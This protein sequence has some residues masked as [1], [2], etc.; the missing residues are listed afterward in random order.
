M[1]QSKQKIKEEI[2]LYFQ[3]PIKTYLNGE[4][5]GNTIVFKSFCLFLYDMWYLCVNRCITAMFAAVRKKFNYEH[6]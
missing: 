2:I 1:N 6:I 4:Y 5:N 3:Q